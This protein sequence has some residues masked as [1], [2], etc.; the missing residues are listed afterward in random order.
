[1]LRFLQ[2]GEIDVIMVNITSLKAAFHTNPELRQ[3]LRNPESVKELSDFVEKEIKVDTLPTLA[4]AGCDVYHVTQ[5]ATSLL[6]VP[7]GWIL[8]EVLSGDHAL[9]YGSRKSVFF[10]RASEK[11]GYE[12]AETA[13]RAGGFDTAKMKAVLSA[14]NE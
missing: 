4:A 12:A 1:M 2:A 3:S 13:L 5:R 6:F 9:T 10:Q 11:R 7:T 14:F 8:I